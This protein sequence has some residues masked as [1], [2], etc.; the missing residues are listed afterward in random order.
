MIPNLEPLKETDPRGFGGWK[1]K[2][3][4]G[5]GGYSTI[6][7]GEKNH[8]LAAI[9]MIRSGLLS[10]ET[11]FNRFATEINNLERIDHPGIAKY[12][13][14]DL[15]TDVP[16]IAVEYIEGET[17][18]HRVKTRAPLK[19]EEWLD[20]LNKVADA[21]DYCH[22]IDITHKDVSPGN[23]ILG[24][25]GPKLIDF[26]IS[27][28][29]GDQRVTQPDEIVGTPAYMSPE[30]WDSEPRIE[31]DYFSLGATFVFA[32]T[33]HEAFAGKSKQEVRSAIWN[34]VPNLEGLNRTQIEL[35][36]PLLFKD[37]RERPSLSELAN[38]IM[39][40]KDEPEVPVFDRFLE[41]SDKKLSKEAP[42]ASQSTKISKPRILVAISAAL[43]FAFS[44]FVIRMESN[45]PS[46]PIEKLS[47]DKAIPA[48]SEPLSPTSLTSPSRTEEP[49]DGQSSATPTKESKTPKKCED[50][51]Y[52]DNVEKDMLKTCK[53]AIESGD[54]NGYYGIGF[55]YYEQGN[56][57]EA[58]SWWQKGARENSA[59]S[60]YR[61]AGA[62]YENGEIAQAK[63]WY[64]ECVNASTTNG[65]K[66]WCMNGLGKIY[67]F[68]KNA[69]ESRRWY[70]LSA[71][72]GDQEG[73]YRV[74][75]S[76]SLTGEWQKALDNFLMIKNPNMGTKT[77]IAEAYNGL[78]KEN[79]ALEWYKKAANDGSADALVNVG[80]IYYLKKDYSNA[81][82]A[83][84]KASTLGS[85]VASYKL[86]RLYSDQN[87]F[88]EATK[89]DKI[90]ASQGEIGSI[91]FYGFSF[92]E[93]GDYKNAKI[94]YQKGVEKEDTSSMV[95]LGAISYFIEDDKIGACKL[96]LRAADLGN[97]KAK[98]NVSKYCS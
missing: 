40:K 59:L 94:W 5:E 73:Y 53:S 60:M 7:L 1:I 46:S 70:Q 68:E 38:A 19:M 3:R 16:Y 95:Q 62:L 24:K 77:L 34:N 98:E 76:Y 61:L 10:D 64:E 81:I 97:T 74:G 83:W 72:L 14:S 82:D 69:K 52:L 44:W 89:Y 8:Q 27:Y 87:N 21:L 36:T 93:K 67:Y 37:F 91:F 2:G 35:I 88:D 29:A 22:K 26:G 43:I 85:G 51:I 57:K 25:D 13:E 92:Q 75:I 55:Y 90:G 63:K 48:I 42:N 80:V 58:I 71:D 17:L 66:S 45:Q 12:L 78:G 50:F 96:W 79:Q 11:V 18:E 49:L 20:C 47:I 4:L 6:F 32:G 9:K 56:L 39:K 33:G 65:G 41:N 28:H 86:A 31:M 84:K 54:L 23:I 30:H 15:S